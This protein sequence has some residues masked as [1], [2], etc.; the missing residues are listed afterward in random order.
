MRKSPLLLLVLAILLSCK[1]EPERIFIKLTAGQ[2]Y[3]QKMVT[4]ITT[5]QTIQGRKISSTVIT[6]ALNNFEVL[7]LKDTIYNLNVSYESISAKMEVDGQVTPMMKSPVSDLFDKM[8][9]KQY[10]M[11]MSNTGRVV[12][13]VGADSLFANLTKSLPGLTEEIKAKI[14]KSFVK[15]YGDSAIK[16]NSFQNASLYP[17]RAIKEGDT[18]AVKKLAGDDLYSPALDAVYKVDKITGSEY[19]IS[20]KAKMEVG[21]ND[22]SSPLFNIKLNGTMN[23]INKIDKK[24]GLLLES[25]INQDMIGNMK[26]TQGTPNMIGTS[27]LTQFKTEMT[28]TNSM[29]K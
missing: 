25:K 19:I 1:T 24:T 7:E 9:G 13:T 28:L 20:M 22:K 10:Q 12:E 2:K 8:K 23:S 27:I 18:W 15:T 16:K 14:A 29:L 21:S 6:E 5:S 3:Q 26:I 11:K 17:N 4:K